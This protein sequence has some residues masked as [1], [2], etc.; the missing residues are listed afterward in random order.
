MLTFYLI[1]YEKIVKIELKLSSGSKLNEE[2]IA[3][4]STKS[5]VEKSLS[6]IHAVKL[7]IEEIAN[8]VD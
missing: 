3:V 6:D 1:R 4:L 2:Q 8:E 7:Q 5:S